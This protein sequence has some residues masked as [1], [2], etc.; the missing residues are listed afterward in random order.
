M[1]IKRDVQLSWGS[2]IT[3]SYNMLLMDGWCA[4]GCWFTLALFIIIIIYLFSLCF[5]FPLDPA[6]FA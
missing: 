6:V 2:S 1:N 5:A 3:E 4:G